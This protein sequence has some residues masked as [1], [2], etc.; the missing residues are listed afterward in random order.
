MVDFFP[1][2][3][4]I[5]DCQWKIFQQNHRFLWHN[6]IQNMLKNLYIWSQKHPDNLKSKVKALWNDLQ[7]AHNEG[8]LNN[9]NQ[10]TND[11]DKALA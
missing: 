10:M 9:V 2:F 11:L 6:N 1:S 3:K 7:L 4:E 8:N 5:M